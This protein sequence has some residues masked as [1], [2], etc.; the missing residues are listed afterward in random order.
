MATAQSWSGI[1]AGYKVLKGSLAS[2]TFEHIKIASYSILMAAAEALGETKIARVD[3]KNLREEAMAEW[4]KNNPPVTAAQF[5]A[6]T[7]VI[8]TTL[9]GD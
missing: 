5:L 3:E 2:Y 1:F 9:S 7:E 6:R 4:L 8:P